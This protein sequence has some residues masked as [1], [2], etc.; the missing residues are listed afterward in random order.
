MKTIFALLTL[1]ALLL[2]LGR[3]Q[4]SSVQEKNCLGL[5]CLLDNQEELCKIDVYTHPLG[6]Y[7]H[8]TETE[9][10]PFQRIVKEEFSA[11]WKRI[12]GYPKTL[13][14]A[15][16]PQRQTVFYA[17]KAHFARVVRQFLCQHRP[18]FCPN[19]GKIYLNHSV[20][21]L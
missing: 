5:N 21:R 17:Q 9:Q 20:Y 7:G 6:N 16:V 4:P 1:F 19:R 14:A 13:S 8:K 15:F 11:Y 10:L 3:E 12:F 2:A 18:K